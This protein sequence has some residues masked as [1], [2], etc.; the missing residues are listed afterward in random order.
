MITGAGA[1]RDRWGAAAEPLMYRGGT[2]SGPRGEA[3]KLQ[4]DKLLHTLPGSGA[5]G[6]YYKGWKKDCQNGGND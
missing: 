3:R 1:E 6:S 5:H 2:A 4:P